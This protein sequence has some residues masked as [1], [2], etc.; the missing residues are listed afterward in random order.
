MAGPQSSS[1]GLQQRLRREG[2]AGTREQL[3]GS[4]SRGR[5]STWRGPYGPGAALW[6]SGGGSAER[7]FAARS[8]NPTAQAQEHRALGTQPRIQPP[9]RTGRGQEGPGQQG[10]FCPELRRS[11]APPPEH[12]GP[13]SPRDPELLRK[14]NP[15]LQS[16]PL[17]LWL[18]LLGPHGVNNP[19]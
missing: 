3:R 9:P 18:S 17:P 13:C 5:G 6:V 7:V 2:A 8:A 14:L 10:S 15:G 19:H 16:Q 1:E 12:P 4:S 11:V